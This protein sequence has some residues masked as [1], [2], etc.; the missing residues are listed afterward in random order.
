MKSEKDKYIEERYAEYE[1]KW[2]E[3][4]PPPP[5]PIVDTE[6]DKIP[7]HYNVPASAFDFEEKEGHTCHHPILGTGCGQHTLDLVVDDSDIGELRNDGHQRILE[8]SVILTGNQGITPL[9][10]DR[11]ADLLLEVSDRL[12]HVGG[13]HHVFSNEAGEDVL[14]GRL[15]ILHVFLDSRDD[16]I[17]SDVGGRDD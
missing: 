17:G 6:R 12:L 8:G 16:I 5:T 10:K 2:A 1:K 7:V 11:V 15:E 9:V 14:H 13:D 4:P 3:N